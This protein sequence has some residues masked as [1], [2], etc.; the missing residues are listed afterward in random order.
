MAALYAS[1]TTRRFCSAQARPACYMVVTERPAFRLLYGG[2]PEKTSRYQSPSHHGAIEAP[3][4]QHTGEHH[5]RVHRSF[6]EGHA[7]WC[8]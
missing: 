2:V 7:R 6:S 8:A 1:L 4:G 3:A 5:D